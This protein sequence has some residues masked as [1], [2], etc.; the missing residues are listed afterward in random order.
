L[1]ASMGRYNPN[2]SDNWKDYNFNIPLIIQKLGVTFDQDGEEL[3]VYCPFH[4]EGSRPNLGM[5]AITGLWHCWSCGEKGNIAS[6]V[7]KLRQVSYSDAVRYLVDYGELPTIKELKE[8]IRRELDEKLKTKYH[9]KFTEID[10]SRYDI[11]TA[12]WLRYFSREIVRRFSLGF[13]IGSRRGVIPIGFGGKWVGT[14]KRAVNDHQTPKY[15]YERG[16]ETG[17]VLY[18]WDHLPRQGNSCILV[19][20]ARDAL[21]LHSF[22]IETSLAVLGAGISGT[23]AAL[24]YE[25]FDEV[26]LW[27]DNDYSGHLHNLLGA[28]VL[29][30][31]V[32]KVYVAPYVANVKD[33]FQLTQDEALQSLQERIHW[34]FLL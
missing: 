21:R 19:E 10:I 9:P 16:F 23:Q 33:Q 26:T 29:A 6:F 27:F 13:D 18:P 22:G 28:E 7:S 34:S 14:I 12:W 5:N 20:G 4:K 15:L 24:V 11:A 2:R 1:P 8:Q 30:E 3:T 32:P 25:N 31:Y 17:S